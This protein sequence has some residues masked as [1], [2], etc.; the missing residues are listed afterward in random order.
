MIT[1]ASDGARKRMDVGEEI[2]DG[3][4]DGFIEVDATVLRKI[5]SSSS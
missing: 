5:D 2:D 3:Y 4:N 1:M